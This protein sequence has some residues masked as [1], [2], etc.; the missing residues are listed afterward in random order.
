MLTILDKT[1]ITSIVSAATI[2]A[3]NFWQEQA[4][5]IHTQLQIQNLV[6]MAEKAYPLL[7]CH[8]AAAARSIPYKISEIQTLLDD[9]TPVDYSDNWSVVAD[10]RHSEQ[11]VV[12]LVLAQR[13]PDGLVDVPVSWSAA[14]VSAGGRPANLGSYIMNIQPTRI[15]QH[16]GRRSFV[17]TQRRLPS[18]SCHST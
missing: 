1:L 13:V 7:I 5:Q 8:S 14:F 2:T 6:S 4:E 15:L 9:T 11:A 18:E 17:R 10:G 3:I 16:K 12:Y